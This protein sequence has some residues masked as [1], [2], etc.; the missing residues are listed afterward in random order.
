MY[1]IKYWF[2]KHTLRG[3]IK[4]LEK[5]I[6]STDPWSNPIRHDIKQLTDWVSKLQGEVD[7]LNNAIKES[8]IVEDID[9]SDIKFKEVKHNSMLFGGY[10]TREAYQ[11]N[12]VKT[13]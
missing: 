1:N 3:R 11:I 2:K 5:Q 12:K 7:F 10:T 6:I 4:T 8:G 9:V 13:K